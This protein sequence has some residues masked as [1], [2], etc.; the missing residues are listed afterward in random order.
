MPRLA[1]LSL[2]MS[3][4]CLIWNSPSA[5]MVTVK[6]LSSNV[7]LVPLKSK[8]CDSSRFAWSTALVSSWLSIS[9]T[10]SKEGMRDPLE[11]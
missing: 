10:T 6:S 1:S 4:I 7:H 5:L 8:R 3:A 11:G 2:R 9:E